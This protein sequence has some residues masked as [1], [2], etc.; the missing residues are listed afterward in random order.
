M[1]VIYKKKSQIYTQT[2]MNSCPTHQMQMQV[3]N[4]KK[5]S[6]ILRQTPK[7]RHRITTLEIRLIR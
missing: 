2:L 6:I 5:N 7:T 4:K 3:K 1:H